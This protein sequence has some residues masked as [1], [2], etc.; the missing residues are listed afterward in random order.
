MLGL[1]THDTVEVFIYYFLPLDCFF[2]VAQATIKLKIL[3]SGYKCWDYRVFFTVRAQWSYIFLSLL[4]NIVFADTMIES[5]AVSK[6]NC[7]SSSF[8]FF[9]S[10][11]CI[12]VCLHVCSYAMSLQYPKKPEEGTE[13]PTVVSYHVCSWDQTQVL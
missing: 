5:F 2:Y 6:M 7:F 11:L 10:I 3:S 1:Q 4:L 13:W 12:G 9:Y 8:L